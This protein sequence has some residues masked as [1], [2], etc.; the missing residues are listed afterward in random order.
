MSKNLFKSEFALWTYYNKTYVLDRKYFPYALC[1]LQNKRYGLEWIDH[2]VKNM[3]D[4]WH[5]Q[6]FWKKALK[7]VQKIRIFASVEPPLKKLANQLL[8]IASNLNNSIDIPWCISSYDAFNLHHLESV[9]SSLYFLAI[10]KVENPSKFYFFFAHPWFSSLWF[11]ST[12]R[13]S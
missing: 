13:P 7:L 9:V 5:G 1:E 2:R 11:E 4:I 3:S 12:Q 8:A 6:V 10:L